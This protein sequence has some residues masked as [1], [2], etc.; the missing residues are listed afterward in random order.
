MADDPAGGLMGETNADPDAPWGRKADGTPKRGPG[1]RPPGGRKTGPKPPPRA[2]TRPA[3]GRKS[4]PD[5]RP[6]LIG[7]ASV[8]ALPLRF[9]SPLDS[10]AVLVHAPELAEAINATAQERPEV[11]ALC[12]RALQIGPYGLIIGALLKLGAQIAE[13]HSWLP[14]EVTRT[15][16]AI[17]RDE[18]AAQL[19]AQIADA[20]PEPPAQAV[21]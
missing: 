7:L 6:G 15:M 16:G 1:G 11:A 19:G 18:L 2:A 9:S 10:A 21:A 14:P 20:T 13:N 8:I 3:A 5:Y 4:A 17:P 12:E